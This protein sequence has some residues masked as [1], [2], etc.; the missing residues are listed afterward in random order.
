MRVGLTAG[1]SSPPAASAV[2]TGPELALRRSSLDSPAF[3]LTA[4]CAGSGGTWRGDVSA[5][6]LL[7]T[8]SLYQPL[9]A[10][11]DRATGEARVY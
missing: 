3:S 4:A 10:L 7:L 6:E 2:I 8:F 1:P 5:P 9:L 11:R